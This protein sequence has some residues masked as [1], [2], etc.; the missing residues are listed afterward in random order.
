MSGQ[1]LDGER[2]QLQVHRRRQHL[3]LVDVRDEDVDGFPRVVQAAR[4]QGSQAIGCLSLLL[5]CSLLDVLYTMI[6]T[7]EP[8]G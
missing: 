3:P 2:L 4:G 5:Y 6:A 1:C 8:P 7:L